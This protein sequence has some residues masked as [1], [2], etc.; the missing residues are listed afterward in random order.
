MLK[1]GSKN[2]T[3]KTKNNY[4]FDKSKLPVIITT[5]PSTIDPPHVKW[6]NCTYVVHRWTRSKILEGDV[7]SFPEGG[8]VNFSNQ[9][10]VTPP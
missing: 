7:V 5:E 4:K 9:R 10:G 1:S 6:I 2:G 8:G 3:N